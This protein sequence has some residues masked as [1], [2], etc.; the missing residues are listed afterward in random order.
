MSDS[1]TVELIHFLLKFSGLLYKYMKHM[2]CILFHIIMLNDDKEKAL[3]ISKS[4]FPIPITTSSFDD[5]YTKV[6]SVRKKSQLE[7]LA[8]I[9]ARRYVENRK[10]SDYI[11]LFELGRLYYQA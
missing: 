2:Q 10:P 7:K 8:D 4:I 3:S 6:K 9:R 5:L 1:E 11:K